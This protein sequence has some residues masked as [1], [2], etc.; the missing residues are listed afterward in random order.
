MASAVIGNDHL[1]D[2]SAHPMSLPS[3]ERVAWFRASVVVAL[4]FFFR[5]RNLGDWHR[6]SLVASEDEVLSLLRTTHLTLIA[7]FEIEL[8]Q[9]E[10]VLALSTG[11]S[12]LALLL[13]G[14]SSS[15]AAR[16]I[17]AGVSMTMSLA[18]AAFW[19]FETL[20]DE[21]RS[22]NSSD[23]I[24][25]N[26]LI[27]FVTMVVIESEVSFMVGVVVLCSPDESSDRVFVIMTPSSAS[28][29]HHL[30]NRKDVS[31]A[32]VLSGALLGLAHDL[33]STSY[34]RDEFLIHL[35]LALGVRNLRLVNSIILSSSYVDAVNLPEDFI[36]AVLL[37]ALLW[38]GGTQSIHSLHEKVAGLLEGR[39]LG[40]F[41][42]GY[43]FVFSRQVRHELVHERALRSRLFGSTGLLAERHL[44]VAVS[45][46]F[47]VTVVASLDLGGEA[48]GLNN[49]S[50]LEVLEMVDVRGEGVHRLRIEHIDAGSVVNSKLLEGLVGR[51]VDDVRSVQEANSEAVVA[52]EL[53]GLG[54]EVADGHL[55]VAEGEV[56]V[57]PTG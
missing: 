45:N 49:A 30:N 15:M 31:F 40:L 42:L 3:G 25:S 53:R 33:F 48:L 13:L 19:S 27:D 11:A 56:A 16:R 36:A 44:A 47:S 55:V 6:L 29:L 1:T 20:L 9:I 17:R 4:F 37:F 18:P 8:G 52:V 39:L 41:L 23:G 28:A 35:A 7:N 46:L 14:L 32:K 26:V 10:V 57:N 54:D 51:L 5:N 38:V 43:H 50:L 2:S 21:S 24:L 22:E 34:V 12:L